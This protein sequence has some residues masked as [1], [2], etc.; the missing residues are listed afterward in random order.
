M[1]VA[2]ERLCVGGHYRSSAFIRFFVDEQTIGV[3]HIKGER[4]DAF[5]EAEIL[6]GTRASTG[7]VSLIV[8][9]TGVGMSPEVWKR[10]FLPFFSTKDVKPQCL[11]RPTLEL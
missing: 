11:S 5:T 3:L 9:D 8:R 6:V 10:I 7:S 4:P 2:G 1:V